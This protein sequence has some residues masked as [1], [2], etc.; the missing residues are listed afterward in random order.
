MCYIDT[1][2]NEKGNNIYNCNS[3]NEGNDFQKIQNFYT[4][5]KQSQYTYDHSNKNK[6]ITNNIS[7]N[8]IN[9]RKSL[10]SSIY[11]LF[12]GYN[13]LILRKKLK[14]LQETVKNLDKK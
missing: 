7:S 5:I 3:I 1:K 10:L 14:E 9:N 11:H 6:I 12:D 4:G 8:V 13:P 2:K